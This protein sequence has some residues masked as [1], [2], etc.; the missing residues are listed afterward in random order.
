MTNFFSIYFMPVTALM[1]NITYFSQF[2]QFF[3]RG[4]III[5]LLFKS[6]KKISKRGSSLIPDTSL[7]DNAYIGYLVYNKFDFHSISSVESI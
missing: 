3:K 1:L 6:L 7:L 2:L 5:I 4:D